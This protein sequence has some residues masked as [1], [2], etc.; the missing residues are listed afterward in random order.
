M[1]SST[2]ALFSIGVAVMIAG[3]DLGSGKPAQP[4]STSVVIIGMRKSAK[5]GDCEGADV[6]ANTMNQILSKYTSNVKVLVNNQAKKANVVSAI[7]NAVKSDLAI[8]YYSGHGGSE[9]FADTKFDET[10]LDGKD[11]YLCLYDTYMRDNEVWNLISQSK[12]RVFL[13]FDC[14]H[15]KTM[16]RTPMIEVR[17]AQLAKESSSGKNSV[18]MLCWSG[19]PDN[20][21]SYGDNS[22]GV[23]TNW[24][25]TYYRES[26]TY[27]TMWNLVYKSMKNS[28]QIPQRTQLGDGFDKKI[29]R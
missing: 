25:K 26:F 10:E 3:C 2:L 12:G 9:P 27:D 18:N 16:F 14:C 1:K 28:N 5:F 6:D 21:Y 17:S 29:F 20:T 19:C 8:I 13:I 23:F 11:E 22:G 4:D 24:I 15:S 7:S